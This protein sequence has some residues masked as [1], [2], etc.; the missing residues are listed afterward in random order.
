VVHWTLK[1]PSKS[2][3]FTHFYSIGSILIYCNIFWTF[4]ALDARHFLLGFSNI[5][6]SSRT[7]FLFPFIM[8]FAWNLGHWRLMTLTGS[9]WKKSWIF[10]FQGHLWLAITTFVF[11]YFLCLSTSYHYS[12][13]MS[14]W[15]KSFGSSLKFEITITSVKVKV[16]VGCLKNYK[17]F[18][19]PDWV[20]DFSFAAWKFYVLFKLALVKLKV[21]HILLLWT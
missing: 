11:Y 15:A 16:L 13:V 8:D 14:W 20:F 3:C 10:F 21:Q 1:S 4:F 18:Q 12:V 17:V 6:N 19:A 5:I 2:A 7:T 9:S